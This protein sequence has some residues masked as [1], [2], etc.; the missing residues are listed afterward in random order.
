MPSLTK[1]LQLRDYRLILAIH[2]AGQL[3][4]AAEKLALTQPAASRLLAGIEAAIG[5]PL[6]VRKPKGMTAT[7]VGEIL[8]RNAVNLF[9]GLEQTM[10]EVDAAGSGRGG[11]ARVGAVTGGAVAFVVPAIQRLKQSAIGADIHVDVAPSDVLMAGLQNGDYDFVLSRIP[12]GVDARQFTIQR[13]RVEIIRFVVRG[14]HPLCARKTIGLADLAGQEWVIQAAGTPMRQA[15][16]EAFVANGV[17]LPGEIVN[18]TS[19][20]V[21]IAYLASSNAIA[22]ISREV[23]D[24]I[25][26]GV[27]GENLAILDLNE[28]IIVHPY[29]LITRRNQVI[30]PLAGRLRDLVFAGLAVDAHDPRSMLDGAPA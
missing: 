24:L 7:P 26:A 20:L 2:E 11:T 15:V 1:R 27:F 8:A 21:M 22:P 5:A 12:A 19:L 9:N 16:E 6:F 25:G 14:G 28:P 29:H 17:A 18:T 30:S 4:L 10:R 3:A 23:A 13:G